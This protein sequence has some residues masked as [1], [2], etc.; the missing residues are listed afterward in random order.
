M[1]DKFV[2]ITN[3]SVSY[4]STA[5]RSLQNQHLPSLDLLVREAIQNSSDASLSVDGDAFNVNF[6][7]GRFEPSQFNVILDD[8]T[9]E[10]NAMYPGQEEGFIEIRDTKTTGLTGPVKKADLNDDDHGNYFKLVF[11]MGK[12]QSQEDAGGNWGYGKS[13]YYRVGIG[14]VIFY[15]QIFNGVNFEQRLIITYM[16]DEQKPDALLKKIEHNSIGKAWW[17]EKVETAG[18]IDLLPI[19]DATMIADILSI[20]GLSAFKETQTGTSVIIP[21]IQTRRLL[22]EIIPES[23]DIPDDEKSMYGWANS[24]EEY[25][26]LAIQKWYAPKLFNKNLDTYNDYKRLN[27]RV[28]GVSIN[29]EK[30]RF[31]F[32]LVQDLYTTALSH[33]LGGEKFVSLTWGDKITCKEVRVKN[34]LDNQK[35]GHVAIARL[36]LEEL[37]GPGSSIVPH[38]FLRYF[39]MDDEPIVMFSRKLGMII[40]YAVSDDWTKSIAPSENKG[41]I[42]F[43]FY[44]PDSDN[45]L[46]TTVPTHSGETLEKYLRSC[47]KSDHM[48]WHDDAKMDL[49]NKIKR[50]TSNQVNRATSVAQDVAPEGTTSRLAVKLGRTLLPQLGYGRPAKKG[51]SGGGESGG[52]SGSSSAN[53]LFSVLGYSTAGNTM[54][55]E[56]EVVFKNAK[57]H[58]DI[59]IFVESES[60]L[61]SAE[62]WEQDIQTRFPISIASV[63]SLVITSGNQGQVICMNDLFPGIE[64]ISE[65]D[66]A[67]IRISKSDSFNTPCKITIDTTINNAKITGTIAIT[68]TD[69]KYCCSVRAM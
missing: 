65:S 20:F 14:F 21:Y 19:V 48:S 5:L 28:N 3:Y 53:L 64:D 9:D 43:A 35:T 26:S 45:K 63:T 38:K 32:R 12:A 24:V 25:L 13:A 6:T 40:D 23:G 51:V 1:L 27:V 33:N 34:Y 31:F 29:R 68:T 55:L 15:S 44:L 39:N 59:A 7:V 62:T 52:G 11:D 22:D 8:F 36:T 60:G 37:N 66:Y 49:V 50:N 67:N 54:L 30:M 10:L 18:E 57:R 47:E 58:A 42:I 17:G 41:E 46:L 69:K 4:G 61:L 16:E 56:F 2:P